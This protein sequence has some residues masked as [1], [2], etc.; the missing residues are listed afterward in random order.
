MLDVLERGRATRPHVIEVSGLSS[1]GLAHL[2]ANARALLMPS[3][4][5]GYGLPLVEALTLRTPVVATDAPVFRQV[6]QGC[7]IYRHAIDGLGWRA[8][9][10]RL[11][12]P[13]SAESAQ[14]KA[15]TARF[16][17][18]RWPLYFASIEGFLRSL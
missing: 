5:E 3:F 11:A 12:D 13:S 10:E 17:V 16:E 6:T 8:V 14:A 1:A 2:V 18:P 7:A 9:I 4:D 15:A